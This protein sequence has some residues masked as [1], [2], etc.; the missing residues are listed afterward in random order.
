MLT[1]VS[2]TFVTDTFTQEESKLWGATLL[3]P[4]TAGELPPAHASEYLPPGAHGYKLRPIGLSEALLKVAEALTIHESAEKLQPFF[5][6]M[7][8]GAK[9][10]GG[11]SCRSNAQGLDVIHRVETVR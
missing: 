6:P 8:L 9:T 2:Q 1:A 4:I 3:E 7:Q 11:C 10:P 5:E